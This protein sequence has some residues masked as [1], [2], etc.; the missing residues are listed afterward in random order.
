MDRPRP[1][2]RDDEDTLGEPDCAMSGVPPP[3]Q[4]D[5]SSSVFDGAGQWA[6]L[7]SSHIDPDPP[8][9]VLLARLGDFAVHFA[10]VFACS[11]YLNQAGARSEVT[12]AVYRGL[13]EAGIEIARRPEAVPPGAGDGAKAV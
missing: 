6:A 4:T 7:S 10:V 13:A 8:P 12:E 2:D 5:D 3:L 11:D 1:M 9:A